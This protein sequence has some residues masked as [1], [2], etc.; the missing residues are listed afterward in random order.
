[1]ITNILEYLEG[2][3]LHFP[4]RI[5]YAD[6]E[7][8]LTYR[9]LKE[10]AERTGTGIASLI[11]ADHGNLPVIIFM[12]KDPDVIAA[13]M[14]VLM[15]GNFYVP[16]DVEMPAHRVAL[17]IE[18]LRPAL[19]ICDDD[20]ADEMEAA[21]KETVPVRTFGSLYETSPDREMLERIRE[22]RIDTDPAYAIYTSGSTGV[23]KGVLVSHRSL[24]DY[25][26]HFS[27]AARFSDSDV[28]GN[29]VPFHFDAS[30]I[31]I[32]CTL[33][34]G[35]SMV[36][37]PVQLFSMPARLLEY[38]ERWKVTVIRWVPSALNM[39]SAFKALK[40]CRPSA[41]SRIIFGAEAM[42]TKCFNYW[43]SYYPEAFFMQI[44]GP[45]EIT[46]IC[47]YYIIDRDFGDDETIPIGRH[48]KNSGVFLLDENDRL[49]EEKDTGTV[50]E[51]C[52]RGSGLA[53]G[54]INMPD[55]TER[56]FTQN[57]LNDRYPERIY[58]TGDLA[59]YND[60]G[61]LV[62]ASRK[63]HQIKH[64][65]HRIEL[66]EIEAAAS[67]M[68]GMRSAACIFD[69]KNN[70]IIM[71]YVSDALD[72]IRIIEYLKERLPRYMIPNVLKKVEKMPLTSGGKTDRM[73]LREMMIENI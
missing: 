73:K 25:I 55:M 48:I 31:D 40:L 1:M 16:L 10:S 4:D 8:Q 23:P 41:L 14:G 32:Y 13:F 5:S 65:G 22:K 36:I 42:P 29:Q 11:G 70:R 53:N 49:I 64:M 26:E 45:T 59:S 62:F 57:P 28:A 61:E 18:N 52:V 2:S 27:E 63:D 15:S 54:Y 30:L 58:R 38:M 19:I 12:K 66:P 60:R 33:K 39:V 46:G 44:Y 67:G 35:S 3:A 51:I 56:S 34:S 69:E 47:T 6:D 72:D 21:A 50:G 43:R 37:I 71:I 68:E 24:I 17:I 7:K 9:Q 20:T